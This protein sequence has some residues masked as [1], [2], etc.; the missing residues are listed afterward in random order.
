MIADFVAERGGGLLVAGSR[1]LAQRGLIG[2]PLEPVLP[3]ELDDRRGARRARVVRRER[4]QRAESADGDGRGRDASDH[5]PRRIW[6]RDAIEV[7]VAA[8]VRC[9]DA[10]RP[11]ARGRVG[12]GGGVGSR[13]RRLSR[14]RGAAVRAG[15]LD[16]LRRRGVVALADAG[17]VD[18][19]QPRVVLAAGRALACGGVAGSGVRCRRRRRSSLAMPATIDVDARDASFAAVPDAHGDRRRS[20]SMAAARS[21]LSVRRAEAPGRFRGARLRRIEP[22]VYSVHAEATR[23]TASLGTSDRTIYVGGSDREFAD[24]R[25]NEGFLRRLARDSGGRYVRGIRCVARAFVA[26]RLGAAAG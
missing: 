3:V 1:S 5:A 22:G 10:A 24:P 7:G 18:R 16:D 12:P 13:W 19:S 4:A 17:A 20:R 23:G 26:G 15:P 14:R 2:T 9:V 21:R 8:G 25:L 11:A 6:R